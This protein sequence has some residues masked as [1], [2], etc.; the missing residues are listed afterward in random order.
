MDEKSSVEHHEQVIEPPKT[1]AQG[2]NWRQN[3]PFLKCQSCPFEHTFVPTDHNGNPLLVAHTFHGFDTNG[4]P[5]L[6]RIQVKSFEE[7]KPKK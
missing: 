6:R 4:E 7:V 1:N 2:H 5:I 3:G